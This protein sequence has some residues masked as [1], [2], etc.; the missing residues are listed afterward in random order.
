[1]KSFVMLMAT[2]CLLAACQPSNQSS[3]MPQT[4]AVL[5]P[6]L[7]YRLITLREKKGGYSTNE[8]PLML[9]DFEAQVKLAIA[10]GWQPFGG[11]ATA[12]MYGIPVQAM[13]KTE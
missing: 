13:I 7:M 8:Y 10:E 2:L 3:T 6:R 4:T 12:S 1:M 5:K 9:K 11:I